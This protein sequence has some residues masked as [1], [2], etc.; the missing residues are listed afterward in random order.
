MVISVAV[1]FSC[2]SVGI[3]VP[4]SGVDF[5]NR[6]VSRVANYPFH[7]PSQSG[8]SELEVPG[9]WELRKFGTWELGNLGTWEL[10]NSL[11][12]VPLWC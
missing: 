1:A 3:S 7:T 10:G 2:A 6:P 9:T 8:T 11:S 12:G 5:S 4:V